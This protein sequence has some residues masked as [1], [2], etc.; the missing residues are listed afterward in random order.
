VKTGLPFILEFF[1]F[2][3]IWQVWQLFGM[4]GNTKMSSNILSCM[5]PFSIK[6]FGRMPQ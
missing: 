6:T 2:E 4:D 5:M 3:F 1:S